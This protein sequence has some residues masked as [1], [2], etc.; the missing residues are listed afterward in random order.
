[1][2][3]SVVC[4]YEHWSTDWYRNWAARL[5]LPADPTGS[6]IHRKHWEFCAIGHAFEE[7]GMLRPGKSAL[8]FA[9]GREFL[10]SAFAAFG[11]Q[12]LATDLA[13]EGE[14]ENQHAASRSDLFYNNLISREKF[15]ELVTF[16]HVDM[17]DIRGIE[18]NQYDFLWSSCSFEHLGSLDAGLQ[19]VTNAMSYL[20]SGGIAVH[21][22][23]F[24]LSSNDETLT[25]GGNVVYRRRDIE[26]L[27]H[28][29]RKIRCGLESVDFDGG[30]HPFD[31][32]YDAA[33]FMQQGKPHI[34][35][36]LG[37][38]VSTSIL[39]IIHKA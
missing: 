26:D 27:D 29:L 12:I 32:D 4:R 30:H 31:L 18:S 22:T 11:C 8:C 34:K 37:G 35:L 1:M 21:T 20:R 38:F 19:F 25:S 36:D 6:G 13:T 23:E 24:N 33:P 28:R 5:G 10:P 2:L 15:D 16:R 9:A 7:R 14:W 17:R 39:L 3:S